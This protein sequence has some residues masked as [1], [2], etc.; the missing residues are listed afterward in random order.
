METPSTDTSKTAPTSSA[1]RE[2]L[3]KETAP[4]YSENVE[5]ANTAS[6]ERGSDELKEKGS[7]VSNGDGLDHEHEPP[8]ST[9]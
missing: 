9:S 7:D 3:Q 4:G 8:V 6:G 1:G 2:S 5:F